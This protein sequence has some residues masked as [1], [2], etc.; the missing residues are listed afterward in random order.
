MVQDFHFADMRHQVEPVMLFY[1]DGAARVL[2]VRIDQDA[3]REAI[4][5]IAAAWTEVNPDVPFSYAFFTDEYELL[6]R[7]D[8]EFSAILIQFTFIAIIIACVGLYG[9][10][11]FSADRKTKE[12]GIRKVL[13]AGAG[14][15]LKVVLKEYVVLIAV[16][17]LLAW[18]AAWYVMKEWI[19]AFVYH[20][21]I[22]F[23]SFVLATAGTTLLA[24]L[25]VGREILK[26]MRSR[27]A[28]SLRYE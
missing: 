14:S 9:L 23:S 5:G 22:P 3:P 16:A 28:N 21:D 11:S 2:S 18:G 7:D 26:A 12:I 8:E 10:S 1:Q 24:L 13:G 25:T 15:L 17:N 20:T 6:F 19:A 27:P 4:E